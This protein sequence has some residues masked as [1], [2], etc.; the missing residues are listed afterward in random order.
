[1]TASQDPLVR[2]QEVF[3]RAGQAA[4]FDHV[5]VTLAT[6]SAAGRPSARVVLLR[7]VDSTGFVFFTNYQSRKGRELA[8]NPHAALCCYWPWIDEQVR[9]EGTIRQVDA[10][11]SDRYFA[12]RP[13]DSQIG[14]WASSQSQLLDGRAVLE[15]RLRA[16]EAEYDGREVPRP[17]HWGGYRLVPE[18]IEFWRAA[19][20][21]LHDRLVFVRQGN[22]WQSHALFP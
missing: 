3:A 14:A 7:G 11:E 5:A 19:T 9:V 16:V 15:E 6:A 18:R 20:A 1:V 8:E 21:R 22:A 12:G 4:P 10:E 13:R 17:P 2:F